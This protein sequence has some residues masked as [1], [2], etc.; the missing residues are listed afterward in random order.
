MFNLLSLRQA[1]AWPLNAAP[2]LSAFLIAVAARVQWLQMRA[3]QPS[4]LTVREPPAYSRLPYIAV[5]AAQALL[6][7]ELW[8]EGLTIRG[9]GMILGSVVVVA[10]AMSR[11]RLA[12]QDNAVLQERL[13]HEATHDHL[14]GLPNRALL[15]ERAQ[16]F[17]HD[18]TRSMRHEAVLLL[19][20]D[21]FKAVN[22]EFGHQA[23]DQ[24]L[25]AV[26]DRL[27]A[28]VRPSDTVARLGGDEFVV[29]LAGTT[30]AGA[31]ATARRIHAA[32][33]QPLA[34]EGHQLS[35][36]GSIGVAV[37][38]GEQFDALLRDADLA[39]YRA[40]PAESGS[41]LYVIDRTPQESETSPADAE[42]TSRPVGDG[43]A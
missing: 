32:L 14:T 3:G 1:N 41:G 11:L 17:M 6:V 2:L 13:R 9:W 12:F 18:A 15:K 26:A 29:L 19:D 7:V 36:G 23:G 20:L 35:P 27:R 38:S 24:L 43:V 39:M 28:C 37:G 5:A 22:D 40:K 31:V 21:D 33:S 10:L 42:N 4:G 34:V 25:V 16:E 8:D 30:P